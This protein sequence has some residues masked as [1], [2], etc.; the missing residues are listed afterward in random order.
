MRAWDEQVGW[1]EHPPRRTWRS[2]FIGWLGLASRDETLAQRDELFAWHSS[3]E[4]ARFED[5]RARFEL[6][7][8]REFET[9]VRTALWRADVYQRRTADGHIEVTM[10]FQPSD[11]ETVKQLLSGRDE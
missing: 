7:A 10:H 11:F 3:Y 6:E 5:E 4:R 9:K 8:A 2:R 1:E